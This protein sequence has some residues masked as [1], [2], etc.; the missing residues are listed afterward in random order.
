MTPMIL[1]TAEQTR[2][3]VMAC[4]LA[5]NCLSDF[6]AAS[7]TDQSYAERELT[8][9]GMQGLMIQDLLDESEYAPGLFT[10]QR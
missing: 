5:F 10:P 7:M 8:V 3:R 2:E 1:S 6:G 9:P 4:A